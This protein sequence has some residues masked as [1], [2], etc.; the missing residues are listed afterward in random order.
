MFAIHQDILS[1]V[2][3]KFFWFTEY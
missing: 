2:L 3:I 1:W